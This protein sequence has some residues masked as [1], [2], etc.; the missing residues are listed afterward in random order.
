MIFHPSSL[1][2]TRPA[3]SPPESE[4]RGG[5][6]LIEGEDVAAAGRLHDG[7]AHRVR[8][9]HRPGAEPFQPALCRGV[10]VRRRE[11]NRHTG[12]LVDPLEKASRR[13]PANAEERQAMSLGDD[14]ARGD[15]R[16]AARERV[17]KQTVRLGMMLVALAAERD[18]GAAIDEQAW[19]SGD[20]WCDRGPASRQRMSRRGSAGSWRSGRPGGHRC[21]R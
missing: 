16:D 14:E 10:I 5:E 17:S 11:V 8:V 12:A 1:R 15:E 2:R 18:P 7:E 13:L 4:A 21:R 20:G 19:R 3:R 6:V 9:R